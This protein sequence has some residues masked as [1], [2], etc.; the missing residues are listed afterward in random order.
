M[1]NEP[2]ENKFNTE[3]ALEAL[4][5]FTK[6]FVHNYPGPRTII[7]NPLWHAPKIFRAAAHAIHVNQKEQSDYSRIII[8]ARLRAA[9]E[10]FCKVRARFAEYDNHDDM[11]LL[12]VAEQEIKTLEWVL[13]LNV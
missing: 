2:T 9:K 11:D 13:G 3:I 5:A 4:E 8:E 10:E 12:S 7:S 1:S 6:Y